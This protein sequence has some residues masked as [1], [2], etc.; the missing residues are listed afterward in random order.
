MFKKLAVLF[1]V[2][3][4]SLAASVSRADTINGTQVTG[5]L[6]FLG[7]STNFFTLGGN[8]GTVNI[9]SGVEFSY[10]GLLNT[11]TANFGGTKLTVTDACNFGICASLPFEMTFTDPA[12]AGFT[13]LWNGLGLSSSFADHTLTL[14]FGGGFLLGSTSSIY[15]V[16]V[17]SAAAPEPSSI[18]FLATGLLGAAGMVRRRFAA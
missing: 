4:L 3:V 5:T 2:A 7:G 10:E 1:S 6:T 15:N 14:N 13:T 16:D 12:F 9:G 8:S 18:A 17:A 11:D